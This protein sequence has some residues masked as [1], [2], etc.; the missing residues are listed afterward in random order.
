MTTCCVFDC[1]GTLLSKPGIDEAIRE[2][3]IDRWQSA[4]PIQCIQNVRHTMEREVK[5]MNLSVG[6]EEGRRRFY[7]DFNTSLFRHLGIEADFEDADALFRALHDLRFRL[8]PE[9][10][11]TLE[12]LEERGCILGVASNWTYLLPR[13]LR[14]TG[15]ADRFAF[16]YSSFDLGVEKPDPAF[17]ENVRKNIGVFDHLYYIGDSLENDA[18]PADRAGFHAV[19]VDRS[20]AVG[21]GFTG[22]VLRS[23][24]E[25][26]ALL[27]EENIGEN[28]SPK[29]I[30]R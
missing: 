1:D 24:A 10:L 22:R 2:F 17:F 20:G 30:N 25:L 19:L 9:T 29:I 26:P 4:L 15:I 13:V 8:F 11:A 18:L 27:V 28:H 6:D 16:V 3:I 7:R 23:L 5:G 12:T 21:Q 14:E